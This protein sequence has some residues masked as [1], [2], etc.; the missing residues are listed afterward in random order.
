MFTYHHTLFTREPGR[1]VL[2][3]EGTTDIRKA[4]VAN[5]TYLFSVELIIQLRKERKGREG[6]L[7][8]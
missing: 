2:I 8:K 7:K 5:F 4:P 1:G 6:V 3:L